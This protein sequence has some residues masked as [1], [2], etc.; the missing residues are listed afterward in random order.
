MAR[1]AAADGV[2]QWITT[3]HWRD[4][5]DAADAIRTQMAELRTR[6]DAEGIP[7][8]LHPGNE[9]VLVPR[10]T[11]ALEAGT[12]LTLAGTRYLLLET[13]QMERGAFIHSA[14]FQLQGQGYR[15]ILAHPERVHAWHGDLDDLR[16]LVDRG[17]RLQINAQSLLGGF[18]RAVKS[19]AERLVRE[20]WATLLASDA[21]SPDSRPPVLSG[22]LARCA[23]FIGEERARALVEDHPARL[24]RGEELPYADP[25]PARRRGLFSFPWKR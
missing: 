5:P 21:H 18:G 15:L 4:A 3:P 25:Q 16:E 14:L 20:G 12:A 2:R 7:I 6:L 22:A 9:L 1:M 11:E 8:Q 19:Q 10:L 13:A 24:L 17:C 23:Q